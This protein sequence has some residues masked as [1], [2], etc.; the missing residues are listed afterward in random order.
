VVRT[1][2]EIVRAKPDTGWTTVK[3]GGKRTMKTNRHKNE[4]NMIVYL[5]YEYLRNCFLFIFVF[6][7]LSGCFVVLEMSIQ[8]LYV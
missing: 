8:R 3:N 5:K 4:V 2:L 6:F 1:G 7:S